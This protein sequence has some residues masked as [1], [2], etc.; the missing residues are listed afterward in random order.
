MPGSFTCCKV[1]T[2]DI[3]FNFLSEGRQVVENT[4]RKATGV[5]NSIRMVIRVKDT[6]LMAAVV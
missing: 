4:I 1:G 3:L 6:T 2:W 5:K